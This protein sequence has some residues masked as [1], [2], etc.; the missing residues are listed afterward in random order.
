MCCLYCVYL[1]TMY[2]VFTC[3]SDYHNLIRAC[4]QISELV[5]CLQTRLRPSCPVGLTLPAFLV[6]PV[7]NIIIGK[8]IIK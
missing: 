8:L 3:V 1:C 4:D 6:T 5:H 2:Y 7:R